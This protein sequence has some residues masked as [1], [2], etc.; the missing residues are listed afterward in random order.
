MALPGSQK[1]F[2][3]D[4]RNL[5]IIRL[6]LGLICVFAL[7]F[8]IYY[9]V[10]IK[11]LN[12]PSFFDL[13]IFGALIYTIYLALQVKKSSQIDIKLDKPEFRF[14]EPIT[15]TIFLNLSKDTNARALNILFYGLASAGEGVD[16]IC[17][18]ETRIAPGRVFRHGETF[19]FSIPIPK[20][21][22]KHLPKDRHAHDLFSIP[23]YIE[24]KLDLPNAIDILYDVKVKITRN[25]KKSA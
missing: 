25:D 23:W 13:I 20:E 4:T 19:K 5:K 9:S 3:D 22:E 18:Q 2:F 11:P 21:I 1:K 8:I 14:N 17:K 6:I 16:R 12:P 15:G 10:G 7:C 24:A